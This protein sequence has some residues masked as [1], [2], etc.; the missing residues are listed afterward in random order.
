M[1]SREPRTSD[2]VTDH[3]VAE[4]VPEQERRI[5]QGMRVHQET[6][7]KEHGPRRTMPPT[8][9]AILLAGGILLG[10]AG[11]RFWTR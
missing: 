1:A 8:S 2:R 9:G 5:R 4:D 3:S 10:W 7:R 6:W 11:S